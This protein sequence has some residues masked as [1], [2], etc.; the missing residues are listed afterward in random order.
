MKFI[1]GVPMK[2]DEQV[3][4]AVVELQRRADLLDRAVAQH[5]DAVGQR[6]RLD[7]VVGHVDGSSPSCAVQLGDLDPRLPAQRGVEVG[8]RLVEQEHLRRAHDRAA[9][10]DALALA[11][12]EFVRRAVQVWVRF[13]IAAARLDLAVDLIPAARPPA[14]AR[15]HILAHAHVR[16]ER[17]ALEHHR[18]VALAGGTPT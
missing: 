10:R 12:G 4:R 8:Q 11:A 1:C 18:E 17:I 13:R 3:G 16:V 14:S 7:L 6:H 5:H 2:R 9:D 15:S